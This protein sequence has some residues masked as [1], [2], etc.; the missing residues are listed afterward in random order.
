MARGATGVIVLGVLGAL[1]ACKKSSTKG[2]EPAP[3][4]FA[5]PAAPTVQGP[6]YISEIDL[7]R[8]CGGEPVKE[9]PVYD[10][11]RG[12]IH[13][14]FVATAKFAGGAFDKDY[15]KALE[16][17]AT[18]DHKDYE[19]VLC[20]TTTRTTLVKKCELETTGGDRRT[21]ELHD[22][23]YDAVLYETKT[24]KQIA[25]KS[26]ALKVSPTCP[27]GWLFKS[28][29]DEKRADYTPALMSWAKQYVAP[30]R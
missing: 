14:T 13:P 10:G 19:L 15:D 11:A 27:S 12:R 17:W 16:A 6:R 30:G 18:K 20:I 7:E 23:S 8:V 25:K 24:A 3:S 4:A 1:I 22:A 26:F 2:E 21:L 5:P 9:A 29:R 28:S